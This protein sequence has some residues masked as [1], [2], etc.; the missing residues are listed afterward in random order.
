MPSYDPSTQTD[1][2]FAIEQSDPAVY[3]DQEGTL[4]EPG[5]E[6]PTEPSESER[7]LVSYWC[8]EIRK[9]KQHWQPDFKRMKD[10]MKFS[11]G[12]Q[13]PQQQVEDPRYVANITLRQ[14]NQKVAGLYAKNP[15]AVAVRR[16]TLDFKIWDGSLESLQQVQQAATPQQLPD[17]SIMQPDPMALQAA[18]LLLADVQQGMMRRMQADKI[19]K[20]ME[21]VYEYEVREQAIPFKISM[22]QLVRRTITTGVGY[23]KLGFHRL[24]EKLP[25]DVDKITDVTQPA[26]RAER[27]NLEVQ[28]GQREVDDPQSEELLRM[29]VAAQET[30]SLLVKEGLD[31]EFPSSTSIL[32]DPRCRQLKGFLGCRWVAQE[33]MLSP[34]DV[35]E[36][37]GI[38]VRGEHEAYTTD[39]YRSSTQALVYGEDDKRAQ[40][41][42]CAVYELYDK[43]TGTCMTLCDGFPGYLVPPKTPPLQLETFWP[44]KVL[45]FNDTEDEESIFPPS[46]V[47]LMRDMQIEHNVARQRL[48]EHRDSARP[49]YAVP[50]GVLD[51]PDKAALSASAAH[52]VV[53]LKG[54]A[55]NTSVDS[56]LQRVPYNPIDPQLYEVNT[57]FE[58]I[59][60]VVGAQ[61]ANLGGTSGSTA[62]ESSIAESSRMT[63]QGSNAD[64][65]DDFLT[66]LAQDASHVLLME[67]SPETVERIAGP[68][69]AWPEL[70]REEVSQDLQ[71]VIKAGSSGR[72]NKAAEI[73][74][75]Q[76]IAPLLL[77]I[78]GV[79]PQWLAEQAI[80]RLDDRVDV[81]DAIAQSLP[82]IASMNSMAQPQ[83][84]P[85]QPGQNP[86]E[87][88]AQGANNAPTPGNDA[89]LGPGATSVGGRPPTTPGNVVQMQQ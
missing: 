69:Y 50:A 9:A 15:T 16:K 31:Y 39:G 73:Q 44:W 51:E 13:W 20:T 84:A 10:D 28:A 82:S 52:M 7:K 40:G 8:G 2:P 4:A 23:C 60:K 41:R 32:P 79:K 57:S 64:D 67:F 47:E 38:D 45:T 14:V 6:T 48:R 36:I 61:E 54:L 53:E 11:R 74:N 42:L 58:D 56:V 80:Q 34:D 22:K 27:I 87:Q 66:E 76:Q 17:G 3:D 71:L 24:M 65:L 81:T 12:K 70:S 18:Q 55:P 77:Q 33:Y 62:T 25:G 37:Y 89:N 35:K 83:P 19:G 86:G 29:T 59:L 46:D 1:Q 68:G 85:A 30:E 5:A 75:F 43:A 72:P 49:K 26:R 63:S 88:G 21:I 78:P